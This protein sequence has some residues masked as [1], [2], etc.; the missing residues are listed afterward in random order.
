MS[1][2]KKLFGGGAGGAASDPEAIEY[3]GFR[4]TPTPMAEG[5]EFRLCG[6]IELEQDGQTLS[7]TLI[8]ADM[9]R[10]REAAEEAVILKAKQ[11]IDQQGIGLFG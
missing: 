3:K 9:I 5:S 7:H 2:F 1:F 6:K 8:R 4:I 10:S 11:M